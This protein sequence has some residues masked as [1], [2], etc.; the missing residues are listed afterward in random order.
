MKIILL[1]ITLSL[2]A[3][4]LNAADSLYFEIKI[5]P[6]HKYQLSAT[7]LMDINMFAE[8]KEQSSSVPQEIESETV[9]ISEMTTG[10]VDSTGDSF[11]VI[12]EYKTVDIAQTIGGNKRNL[13]NEMVGMKIVGTIEEEKIV[14]VDS[15]IN[16][17]MASMDDAQL[18]SMIE[19]S[20][21][22]NA[23]EGQY[24]KAGDT[25]EYEMPFQVPIPGLQ[26][27]DATTNIKYILKDFDSKTAN[28]DVEMSIR[29][30][31]KLNDDSNV[32]M[33]GDGGGTAKYSIKDN[34]FI[35]YETDFNT[36]YISNLPKGSIKGEIGNNAY[37]KVKIS[38]SK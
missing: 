17:G 11:P 6:D 27:T 10:S 35:E 34:Y 5:K 23:F 33:S 25:L 19:S 7:N 9:I 36:S 8:E 31:S 4:S 13:P 2:T 32:T 21:M 29:F 1:F 28:F 15:T 14:R 38:E 22:L 24:M 37:Q 30:T 20:S 16:G 12:M 26:N 18:A 3:N